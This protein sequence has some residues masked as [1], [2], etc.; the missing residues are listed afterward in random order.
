MKR[1]FDKVL[2]DWAADREAKPMLLR[3]ARQVGKTYCVRTLGRRFRHFAEINFEET[4]EAARFFDGA[5]TAAP[6]AAKLAA[7]CGK[8]V[9]PVE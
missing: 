7:F 2:E 6:I 8:P 4:P 3:G 5:L 9:R 1:L